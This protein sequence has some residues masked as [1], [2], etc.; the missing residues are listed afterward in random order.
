ML[1]DTVYYVRKMKSH[2]TRLIA[3][4]DDITLD[5]NAGKQIRIPIMDF[6]KVF[7][8][9]THRLLIHKLRHYENVNDWIESFLSDRSQAVVVNGERPPH[10]DV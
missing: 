10:I 3:V 9:V 1:T 4:V 8:K 6:S 2:E 5:M 7:D